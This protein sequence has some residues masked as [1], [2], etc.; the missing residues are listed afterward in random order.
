M[1]RRTA[2]RSL[3]SLGV[4]ALLWLAAWGPDAPAGSRDD[5]PTAKPCAYGQAGTGDSIVVIGGS[6]GLIQPLRPGASVVTCSLRAYPTATNFAYLRIRE[7]DP[8]TLAPD[9]RTIALRTSY[10]TPTDMSY[11]DL[12]WPTFRGRTFDPPL[13][14]H[15]IPRVAEPPRTTAAVI[16]SGRFG[17]NGWAAGFQADGDTSLPRAFT[18]DAGGAV[19]PLPGPHP[20][21]AHAVCSDEESGRLRVVQSV[22]RSEFMLW[23]SPAEL[24]QRFRVPEP[25][26]PLWVE[27][28]VHRPAYENAML[29]IVDATGLSSPP[30]RMPPPLVEAPFT[31]D[32]VV[33]D[34]PRWMAHPPFEP[35]SIL[36]PSRE[37]WIHVRS[38][39]AFVFHGRFQ[40][41]G[42]TPDFKASIGALHTRTSSAGAW[43][44]ASAQTLL[45]RIIGRPHRIM[46]SRPTASHGP[47][48]LLVSPNPVREVATLSW[49]GAVGRVR[50]EVFDVHGRRV[51]A[52]DGA[53]LGTWQWSRRTDAG[54]LAPPGAYFVHARDA[55]A[56]HVVERLVVVR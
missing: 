33:D 10:L 38:A 56:G 1:D 49:S 45:F 39:G 19:L 55:I 37:Y 32:R 31:P 30:A 43:T 17:G 18:T 7:W 46:D 40:Y 42:D 41:A 15:S 50:I 16:I 8:T 11:P 24:V 13:V 22:I 48:R 25:V 47:F 35:G 26:E 3:P 36:W 29:G 2:S 53:S 44:P 5:L 51:T 14:T 28:A 21:L 20:V 54:A 52:R 12:H 6:S 23:N 4:T 34:A 27:L 9:S